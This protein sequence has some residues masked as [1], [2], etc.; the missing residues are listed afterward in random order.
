M[1]RPPVP[2]R[3]RECSCPVLVRHRIENINNLLRRK[4]KD[5]KFEFA[6]TISDLT[7][8]FESVCWNHIRP[9]ARVTVGLIHNGVDM[10]ELKAR[11]LA[12]VSEP[13]RYIQFRTNRP[14]CFWF[15]AET[16]LC[17]EVDALAPFKFQPITNYLNE[18]EIFPKKIFDRFAGP[19]YWEKFLEDGTINIPDVF[20]YLYKSPLV[21]ALIDYEFEMYHHHFLLLPGHFTKGFLRNMFYS[22][23]QQLVRQDPLWYALQVAARPDTAWKLI[24]YPYVAKYARAGAT[25]GFVHMDINIKD[26]LELGTDASK[27][28]S[29]VSL[30][31]EDDDNCSVAVPGFHNHIGAWYQRRKSRPDVKEPGVTTEAEQSYLP[32]DETDFGKVIP[33]PCPKGGVRLTLPNVIH[34]SSAKAT[35]SRRT[36]YPWPTR[37]SDDHITLDRPGQL[38]WPEVSACH[39]DFIAPERGVGG[40][41]VTHDRPTVPFP[42]QTALRGCGFVSDSLVGARRWDDPIVVQEAVRLLGDDDDEAWAIV[43]HTRKAMVAQYIVSVSASMDVEL[44]A[45]GGDSYA[46]ISND[47]REEYGESIE[48]E[49][50]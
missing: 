7:D 45:Y 30:D 39:R 34:G 35:K 18:P 15:N 19:G 26:F 32:E 4:D 37:V 43:N 20:S 10:P 50:E 36:I 9:L 40:E 25:T 13:Q 23:I 41:A 21:S 29:S 11:L 44:Q 28:T 17:H 38:T 31:D 48:D 49:S 14:T 42:P 8:M 6:D 22:C 1:D 2:A 46:I 12:V 5:T 16:R 33:I 24:S 27:V 3:T 47:P